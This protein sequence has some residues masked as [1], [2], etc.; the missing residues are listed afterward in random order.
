MTQSVWPTTTRSPISHETRVWRAI[1]VVIVARDDC[2]LL[3]SVR[4]NDEARDKLLRPGANMS[5]LCNRNDLGGLHTKKGSNPTIENYRS[6]YLNWNK[7]NQPQPSVSETEMVRQIPIQNT[8]HKS[9]RPIRIITHPW[10]PLHSSKSA[11]VLHT[12]LSRRVNMCTHSPSD[13][14]VL[15]NRVHEGG[16]QL[17]GAIASISS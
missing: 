9:M 16:I 14:T 4:R 8:R 7:C 12:S 2:C 10:T 3:L 13:K 15:I 5:P 17:D 11:H 1:F 6:R